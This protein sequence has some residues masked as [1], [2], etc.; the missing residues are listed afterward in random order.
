MERGLTANKTVSPQIL[1]AVNKEKEPNLYCKVRIANNYKDSLL[2]S[3]NF[4]DIV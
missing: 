1:H 2:F 3:I 4:L